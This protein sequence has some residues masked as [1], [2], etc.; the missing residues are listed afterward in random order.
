MVMNYETEHVTQKPSWYILRNRY[1]LSILL[2]ELR[3]NTK[4][5]SLEIIWHRSEIKPQTFEVQSKVV[6]NRDWTTDLVTKLF[7]LDNW[8]FYHARQCHA[9]AGPII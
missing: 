9:E 4:L 3:K 1:S 8:P 6:A 5:L 7:V 2:D